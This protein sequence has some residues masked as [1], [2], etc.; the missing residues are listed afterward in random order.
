MCTVHSAHIFSAFSE[1]LWQA[2][3]AH[4]HSCHDQKIMNQVRTNS[5]HLNKTIYL[6]SPPPLS[7]DKL[8]LKNHRNKV[9]HF[10]ADWV[11]F[12]VSFPVIL[13]HQLQPD[14]SPPSTDQPLP[15]LS[16]FLH[17]IFL[18]VSEHWLC[19]LRLYFPFYRAPVF[20]HKKLK[21][22]AYLVSG[23]RI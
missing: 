13:Q 20:T 14:L 23:W 8:S 11:C 22:T 6:F 15:D 9:K 1:P 3:G 2:Q 21:N 10:I 17:F 7:M 12:G 18:D 5:F 19:Q 16:K 4:F